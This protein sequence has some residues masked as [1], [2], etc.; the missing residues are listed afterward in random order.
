MNFDTTEEDL[1]KYFSK[2]GEITDVK[3]LKRPDG[4]SRGRGF[5]KF[6]TKQAAEKALKLHDSE[7]MGRRIVVNMP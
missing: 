2:C 5:I 3:L 4:K 6:T 1:N 7:F